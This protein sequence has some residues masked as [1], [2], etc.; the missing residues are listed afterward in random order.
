MGELV[1]NLSLVWL[2]LTC[3]TEIRFMNAKKSGKI[4]IDLHSDLQNAIEHHWIKVKLRING[5]MEEDLSTSYT[6]HT[7][8]DELKV[9]NPLFT[10]HNVPIDNYDM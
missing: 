8:K 2:Q 6:E 7:K 10:K 3:G 4:A 1:T 5:L 9:H